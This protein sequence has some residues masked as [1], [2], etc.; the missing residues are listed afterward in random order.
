MR[1]GGSEGGPAGGRPR[2]AMSCSADAAK[3]K[4]LWNVK[5]EVRAGGGSRGAPA[6]GCGA[7]KGELSL[8]GAASVSAL[9][10]GLR[11]A[12]GGSS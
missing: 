10:S 9:R 3:E 11:P 6:E 1:T 8:P 2:A 12:P 4:L 5:K 7:G